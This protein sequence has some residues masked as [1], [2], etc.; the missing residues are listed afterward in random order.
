MLGSCDIHTVLD[1]FLTNLTGCQTSWRKVNLISGNHVNFFIRKHQEHHRASTSHWCILTSMDGGS[2]TRRAQLKI[3]VFSPIHMV[4]S[5]PA[6][7]LDHFHSICTQWILYRLLH[8]W[9][10]VRI[11]AAAGPS[12]FHISQREQ[13]HWPTWCNKTAKSWKVVPVFMRL[14][15]WQQHRGIAV[16]DNEGLENVFR[17]TERNNQCQQRQR[18][19]SLIQC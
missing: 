12:N 14:C 13:H 18:S 2:T 7:T 9:R 8:I 4:A 16:W 10:H 11:Y 1:F 19:L 17:Q 3:G 5:L 15:C 6:R